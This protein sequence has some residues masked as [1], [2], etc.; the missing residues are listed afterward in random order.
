[1]WMYG[2]YTLFSVHSVLT[3]RTIDRSTPT[4]VQNDIGHPEKG[5]LLEV[6]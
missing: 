5:H 3:F 4:G 1:M 6:G 2:S